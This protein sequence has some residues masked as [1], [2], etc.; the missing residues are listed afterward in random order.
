MTVHTRIGSKLTG[1][2]VY[3]ECRKRKKHRQQNLRG[4]I[5]YIGKLNSIFAFCV[6]YVGIYRGEDAIKIAE[7]EETV[8][9]LRGRVITYT[10]V[11]R[12]RNPTL[13]RRTHTHRGWW[14]FLSNDVLCVLE[15]SLYP[16]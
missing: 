5:Y 10:C 7:R 14:G 4:Q 13:F 9:A 15:V 6:D 1:E 16:S 11:D 12:P 3:Y 2:R 8:N